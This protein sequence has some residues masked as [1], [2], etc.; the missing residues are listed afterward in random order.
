M[1]Q[2]GL[3]QRLQ[4]WSSAEGVLHRQQLSKVTEQKPDSA[5]RGVGDV[6]LQPHVELCDL[7]D[8]QPVQRAALPADGPAHPIFRRLRS[9]SKVLDAAVRLGD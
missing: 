1:Q 3:L 2:L 8:Y 7:L 5:V 9:Q 6:S 4:H